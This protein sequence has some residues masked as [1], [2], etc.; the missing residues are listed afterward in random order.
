MSE[1]SG[2]VVATRR[3]EE[4]LE[5]LREEDFVAVDNDT[6]ESVPPE[7]VIAVVGGSSDEAPFSVRDLSLT[8]SEALADRGLAV[9]V[10]EPSTSAWG[11]VASVRDDAEAST[12][13]STVD[14]AES[15]VGRIA[16]VLALS[17]ADGGVTGHYGVSDG[18][19]SVIP[20]GS[21]RTPTA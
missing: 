7:S 20:A 10:G 17:Q 21:G 16:I 4:L 3:L 13:V 1:S 15:V 6:G 11:V 2:S 19:E 8:L 9:T 18:A 5:V 14:Q 12:E